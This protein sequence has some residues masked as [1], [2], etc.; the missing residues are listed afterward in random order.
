M[1]K[2]HASEIAGPFMYLN[3]PQHAQLAK[4]ELVTLACLFNIWL[5][6]GFYVESAALLNKF[7]GRKNVHKVLILIFVNFV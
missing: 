3:S 1:N 5:I 4:S 7:R 2:N 6:N